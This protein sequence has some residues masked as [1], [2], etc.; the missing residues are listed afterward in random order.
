MTNEQN[1]QSQGNSSNQGQGQSQL[2]K[3]V[4]A[5]TETAKKS[6]DQTGKIEKR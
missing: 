6:A 1:N 3:E 4:P 5:T 2:P